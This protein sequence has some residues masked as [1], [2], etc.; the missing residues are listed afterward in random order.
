MSDSGTTPPPDD[1]HHPNYGKPS[2][3]GQPSPYGE[4]NPYGQPPYGQP[5]GQPPGQPYGGT[6]YGQPYGYP[7][8]PAYPYSHWIKRVGARVIDILIYCI[9]L[10]IAYAGVAWSL[11]DLQ[12][13][14]DQFGNRTTTGEVQPGGLVVLVIFGLL[15]IA[16][17]VWNICLRQ[18]RTGYSVGKGVLGIKLIRESDGQ[19]MGA[20]MAFLRE[21]AHILDGFC[22]IGYLWP[23]WDRKRQTFADKILSTVVIDQPR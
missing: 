18:G 15:A 1:P 21:L 8:A 20:G 11:S 4:Q 5:P 6:P 12:T 3:Y 9:P 23:L 14:T 22:Y 19:P 2:P 13:T 7:Q 17:W 16:L 10:A